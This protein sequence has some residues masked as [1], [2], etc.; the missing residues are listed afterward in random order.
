MGAVVAFVGISRGGEPALPGLDAGTRDALSQTVRG[1]LVECLPEKIEVRDDWGETKSR[2][3]GLTWKLDG[4]KLEVDKREKEFKHGLWKQAEIVPLDPEKNLRF[5]IVSAVSTAP[6]KF[7]FQLLVAAPIH[8]TA[9]IEHWQRGVKLMNVKT[10]ADATVEMRLDGEVAYQFQ[11]VDARTY[12]A[13]TPRVKT[14]DLKLTTFDWQRINRLGGVVVHELGDML[15]GPIAKQLDR[16]EPKAAEKLNA[17]IAK[18]QDKF[19]IAIGLP[20]DFDFSK[21]SILNGALKPKE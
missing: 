11:T 6:Q 21:W 9:R 16:Q 4:L 17:A 10:E 20:L 13:L 3:S 1:I 19:R 18:K 15:A 5:Q 2:F 8:V 14:V 12:W 7:A